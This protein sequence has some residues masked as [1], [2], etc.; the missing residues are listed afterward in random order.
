MSEQWYSIGQIKFYKPHMKFLLSH[1][2]ELREGNYPEDLGHHIRGSKM[3]C[4]L[5]K[6]QNYE[7]L[8]ITCPFHPCL[9]PSERT[10]NRVRKERNMNKVLELAAEVDARLD[11]V[12]DYIS[13]Y[14]RPT[15]RISKNGHKE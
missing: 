7:G 9:M 13:G 8:C 2:S 3:A 12:I 14:K 15:N 4:K 10:P 11:L 6:A 5:A 1:I